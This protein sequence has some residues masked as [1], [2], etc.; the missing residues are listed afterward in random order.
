MLQ[1]SPIVNGGYMQTASKGS[2]FGADAKL[3]RFDQATLRTCHDIR[4]LVAC[5]CGGFGMKGA[6]IE[7]DGDW[8]HG[9]CFFETFGFKALRE[10]PKEVRGRLTLGDISPVLSGAQLQR[11]FK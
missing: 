4:K 7:H 8:Y 3:V 1:Y 11:L 5:K 10:L 2:E 6:L 9:R